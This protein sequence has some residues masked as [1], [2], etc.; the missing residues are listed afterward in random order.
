MENGVIWNNELGIYLPFQ[1]HP[2]DIVETKSL[3]WN[4]YPI[5]G[6][7]QPLLSYSGGD[8]RTLRFRILLDA[9]A[10]PHPAGHVEEDLRVIRTLS[11]PF[12]VSN[13]PTQEVPESPASR[14][15]IPAPEGRGG[16]PGAP[17]GLRAPRG[18]GRPFGVPPMVKIALGG[19]VLRGVLENL[20]VQE[21]LHGTTPQAAASRACT[22]AWVTFDFIVI[23][24]S[25]M[26]VHWRK[27]QPTGEVTPGPARTG[28][29]FVP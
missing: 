11:V 19:R 1:Y 20:E 14:V 3:S 22:R 24:D 10:S 26:L 29:R 13:K 17:A 12:D 18:A 5:L 21:V 4:R 25:R 28:G 2:E 8:T 15:R 7:G 9:H 27:Q 23:E 6:V 16:V